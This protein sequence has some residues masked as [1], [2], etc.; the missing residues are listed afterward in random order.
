MLPLCH[1]ALLMTSCEVP[2]PPSC[3]PASFASLVSSIA[4]DLSFGW[5]I[6]WQ[7]GRRRQRESSAPRTNAQAPT[8][9]SSTAGGGRGLIRL[10]TTSAQGTPSD[11][12]VAQTRKGTGGRREGLQKAARRASAQPSRAAS[13][14][15][16][17]P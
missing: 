5:A 13:L 15:D 2:F 14:C 11:A 8:R 4:S 7:E 10:A 12:L 1:L 16:Y 3:C 17:R 6:E 9:K